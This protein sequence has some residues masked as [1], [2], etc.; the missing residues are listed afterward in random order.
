MG[1]SGGF[2]ESYRK[3]WKGGSDALSA[4]GPRNRST[5]SSFVKS[6]Y[7]SGG[8]CDND[9]RRNGLQHSSFT[10]NSRSDRFAGSVRCRRSCGGCLALH[11]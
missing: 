3:T 5:T 1:S 6:Y 4:D 11:L 9:R 7:S 10:A 8:A 2:T